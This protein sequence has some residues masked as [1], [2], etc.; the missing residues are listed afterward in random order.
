MIYFSS[1]VIFDRNSIQVNHLYL[2]KIYIIKRIKVG[3]EI[4]VHK[5]RK[6]CQNFENRI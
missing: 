3:L 6:M 5:Q 1:V 4:C 2:G